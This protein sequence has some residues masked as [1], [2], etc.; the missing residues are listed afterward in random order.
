MT[1]SYSLAQLTALHCD[2]PRI[3]DLAAQAGYSAAGIR[4]LPA[5]PGGVHYP[6]MQDGALLRETLAHIEGTGVKVLDLEVISID[7][8]FAA[9]Q[10][11]AFLEVG[12]RLGAQHVLVIGNDTEEERLA[13]NFGALCDAAGSFG[14]GCDLE[15][16]PWTS[17]RD[18]ASAARIVQAASR[19]N[20]GVLVDPIHFAR[21]G[22][23]LG[24]LESLPHAWL[25]YAQVC[26][27]DVP[28]PAT[29]EG[30]MHDARHARLLP[31]EGGIDLPS[32]FS[33]L[34]ADLPISVEIPNDVRASAMGYAAWAR[35]AR[36]RM[37]QVLSG[38]SR[39]GARPLN[40]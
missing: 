28:G 40:G 18:V 2:P 20:A 10:Y 24:E 7:P 14:L 3:L 31:G 22:S 4:M 37:E 8:A 5:T 12:A 34:P 39:G 36:L 6:L 16:V 11:L 21:C 17:V 15:F 19:G 38:T 33:R 1:R 27:A 9:A 25:R 26:D 32:L 30:L 23:T 13:E 29:L 35:E